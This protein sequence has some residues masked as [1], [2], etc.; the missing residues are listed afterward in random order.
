MKRTLLSVA[1]SLAAFSQASQAATYDVYLAG[2]S[3]QDNLL[4][5]EAYNLCQASS[6]VYYVDNAGKALNDTTTGSWGSNYKAYSCNLNATAAT[7]AG[8]A[9]T[10]VVTFHK[11]N[12]GGSAQGVAPL[13]TH[14]AIDTLNINNGNCYTVAGYSAKLPDGTT[15]VTTK[16]CTT[17]VTGDLTAK[18]LDA[19]LS[20]VNPTLFQGI[21]QA[22]Y[23]SNGVVV[24]FPE[25]TSV[26]AGFTVQPGVSLTW[27]FPVTYNLYVALQWAQ[28]LLGAPA[29]CAAGAYTDACMPS[30]SKPFITSLISGAI[31]DWSTVYFNGNQLTAVPSSYAVA[32]ADTTVNFCKRLAG[33]GTAAG[34]YAYFLN[35]PANGASKVIAADNSFDNVYVVPDGGNMEKCLDDLSTGAGTAQ[36]VF[37]QLVLNSS[38]P[39]VGYKGWGFGQQSTDKNVSKAKAYRFVKISGVAP[40][41]ANVY[42]GSYDFT[43]EST[44]QY[45]TPGATKTVN[46]KIVAQLVS[47][48]QNPYN[49]Y[50]SLGK[51]SIQDFGIAGFEGTVGNAVS[52]LST[53]SVPTSYSDA[54]VKAAFTAGTTTVSSYPVNPWTHAVVNGALDGGAFPVLNTTPA[55]VVAP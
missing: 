54:A 7:A 5:A 52:A 29:N 30:L 40:T 42:N 38:G 3:A 11:V 14:T 27:G 13:F 55:T 35:Q 1:I 6:F 53:Y 43:S 20:D 18:I 10:D 12:F 16:G 21:N 15:S 19:G 37:G 47:A 22:Q 9:T 17:T 31:T 23:V 46:Q 51:S 33:S 48:A 50:K 26:P 28:G 36:D 49:I 24:S 25:V 8:V 44:W 34:Q 2:S 41:L 39:G 45:A 32:P 4:L